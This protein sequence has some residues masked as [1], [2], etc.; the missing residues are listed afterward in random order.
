MDDATADLVS[1][2]HRTVDAQL[3]ILQY[4]T[5]LVRLSEAEDDMP[6]GAADGEA[7][8]LDLARAILGET[9]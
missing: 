2:L 1:A 5:R 7:E 8:Y 6:F 9:P 4:S 3:A